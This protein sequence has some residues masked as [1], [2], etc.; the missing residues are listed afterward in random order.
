M[1]I[2]YRGCFPEHLALAGGIVAA[3]HESEKHMSISLCAEFCVAN[4]ADD[5]VPFM[6]LMASF[7][8]NWSRL[9]LTFWNY[10]APTATA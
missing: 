5:S 4:G 8:A 1:S 3:S 7:I 6:G 10:R 9:F 2:V